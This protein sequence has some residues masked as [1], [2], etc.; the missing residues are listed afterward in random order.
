MYWIGLSEFNIKQI[1]IFHNFFLSIRDSNDRT[2][3]LRI[4][5]GDWD[6]VD[7]GPKN[8]CGSLHPSSAAHVERPV[9]KFPFPVTHTHPTP[10]FALFSSSPCKEKKIACAPLPRGPASEHSASLKLHVYM[11]LIHWWTLS[12]SNNR[13]FLP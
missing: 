7:G 8:Y 6:D 10:G 3:A 2:H 9:G 5:C 4:H 11:Q 13:S 1:K 12:L